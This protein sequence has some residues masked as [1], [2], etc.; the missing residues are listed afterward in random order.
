MWDDAEWCKH[1]IGWHHPCEDCE[2]EALKPHN[3]IAQ[4][5]EKDAAEQKLKAEVKSLRDGFAAAAMQ[6]TKN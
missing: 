2:V 6:F 3:L 5:E 4:I 1:G